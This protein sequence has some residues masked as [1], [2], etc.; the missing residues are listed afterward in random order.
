M[1]VTCATITVPTTGTVNVFQSTP[2]NSN[3][4]S[5]R[6]TGTSVVYLGTTTSQLFPLNAGEFIGISVEADDILVAAATNNNGTGTAGSLVVLG[7][8]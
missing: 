1:A 5:I 4:L 7:V 2:E 8:G 3:S 6:N